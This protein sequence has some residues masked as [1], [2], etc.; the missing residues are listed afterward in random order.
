[1]SARDS[2]FGE[3]L[4]YSTAEAHVN[5]SADAHDSAA[6]RAIDLAL[7]GDQLRER[8]A[9]GRAGS[10]RVADRFKRLFVGLNG[11]LVGRL[12]FNHTLDLRR[13]EFR[14]DAAFDLN[15]D[16]GVGRARR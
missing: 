6:V 14:L 3:G 4:D 16:F 10:R 7:I 11:A 8:P 9:A 5:L 2:I 1:M 13:P 12:A 15:R